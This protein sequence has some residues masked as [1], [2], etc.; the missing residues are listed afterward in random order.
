MDDTT[1]IPRLAEAPEQGFQERAL[2]SRAPTRRR[3]GRSVGLLIVVALG[4]GLGYRLRPGVGPQPG[5][6][7]Q[8]EAQPVIAATVGSGD[9]RMV[10]NAL[11]TVTPLATVTV[12]TQISGRA[13]DVAFKEGQVV[14][15]G[16]S[17][18]RIDP[19]PYELLKAQYDGQLDHDQALVAQA[20][21]D[22][23]RYQRLAEQSSIARQQYEDQIYLVQQYQGTVKVDQAQSDQ[24]MLNIEYCHIVSPITGYIGLRAVDPGNYL[25]TTNST[26]IAVITQ[27]QPIT[28]VFPI[29]EDSLPQVREQMRAGKT[30]DVTAYDRANVHRLA[31]GKLMAVDS[32]IDTSTGTVRLRAQFDNAD[33]T[34]FPNQFVNARL[35]V[36]TL[37]DVVRVPNAAL[38]SNASH[39]YVYLIKP[40]HTASI[41][42][43]TPG[44]TDGDMTQIESG[45]A[46][47]DRVVVEG[48][49]RLRDGALVTIPDADLQSPGNRPQ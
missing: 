37:H 9:I 26:A 49:D 17:L 36:R 25:Q 27:F 20:Q 28:V 31:A 35:L 44:L 32:Q 10:V 41:R 43:V 24:Q 45:L 38:Q 30:L 7:T 16:D 39:P 40:D 42:P 18:V 34:L 8:P 33:E 22:L 5:S 4:L 21:A 3:V 13:T 14:Q 46:A 12:Q 23:T 48:A 11:G 19:R 29:P 2:P 6:S 1:G 47:G 15:K